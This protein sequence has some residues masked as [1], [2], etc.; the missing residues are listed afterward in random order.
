[1]IGLFFV[2]TFLSIAHDFVFKVYMLSVFFPIFMLHFEFNIKMVKWP[3]L[4]LLAVHFWNC[5]Y[6]FLHNVYLLH[7]VASIRYVF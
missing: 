2:L 6:V 5:L 7:L 4:S 3:N 1:M